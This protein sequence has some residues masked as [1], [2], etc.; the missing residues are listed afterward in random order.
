MD[1]LKGGR[2]A[3]NRRS[4]ERMNIHQDRMTFLNYHWRDKED[5][6]ED[7]GNTSEN[8]ALCTG[9]GLW[10]VEDK[11]CNTATI[12]VTKSSTR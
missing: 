8:D 2:E 5:N 4:A 11:W 3:L 9:L 6:L 10:F 12:R 7:R 1:R